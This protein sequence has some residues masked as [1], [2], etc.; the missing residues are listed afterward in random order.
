MTIVA[1][2]RWLKLEEPPI[3]AFVT[4]RLTK[5]YNPL[6][7]PINDPDCTGHGQIG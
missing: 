2:A 5:D 4:S 1:L 7:C 3:R 6:V